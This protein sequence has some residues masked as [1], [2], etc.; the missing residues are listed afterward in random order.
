MGTDRV[1]VMGYART[2]TKN[3]GN[4]LRDQIAS[5]QEYCSTNNLELVETYTDE[6]S[7]AKEMTD[8]AGFGVLSDRIADDP[9]IKMVI[10]TRLDRVSRNVEDLELMTDFFSHIGVSFHYL[11]ASEIDFSK[12]IEKY[13]SLSDDDFMYIWRTMSGACLG[14]KNSKGTSDHVRIL[15]QVVVG[16]K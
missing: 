1:K 7:G 3:Q 13:P 14:L 10:S 12:L 8:R 6:C 4:S 15:S 11:Q 16:S 2:S 9:E 5:I